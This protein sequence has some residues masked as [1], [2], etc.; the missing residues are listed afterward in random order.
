LIAANGVDPA[1]AREMVVKAML[2]DQ[3][4]PLGRPPRLT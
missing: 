4:V 3:P 1:L 2:V